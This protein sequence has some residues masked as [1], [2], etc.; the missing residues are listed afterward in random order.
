AGSGPSNLQLRILSAIVLV[1][2]ALAATWAGGIWYRLL[3]AAIAAAVLYEWTRMSLPEGGAHRTVLAALLA[4]V[5][6][7]LLGGLAMSSVLILLLCAVIVAAVHA[8]R[9]NAGVWP[10]AGLAYAG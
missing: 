6:L 3:A 10:V 7:A 8:R 1:A 4:L 2:V 5:L 9:E